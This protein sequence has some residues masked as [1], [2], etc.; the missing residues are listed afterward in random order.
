MIPD[1]LEAGSE[2]TYV[3]YVAPV[4]LVGTL[5]TGEIDTWTVTIPSFGHW[6]FALF[7]GHAFTAPCTTTTTSLTGVYAVLYD[8]AGVTVYA[9]FSEGKVCS[10]E[11]LFYLRRFFFFFLKTYG[12]P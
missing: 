8:L 3:P 9:D 6:N 1:Q 5:A 10:H 2:A 12:S 11:I 4:R 7:D